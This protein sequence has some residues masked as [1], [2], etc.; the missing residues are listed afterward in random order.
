[1]AVIPR[2]KRSG[3]NIWAEGRAYKKSTIHYKE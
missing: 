2:A 3:G 1:M